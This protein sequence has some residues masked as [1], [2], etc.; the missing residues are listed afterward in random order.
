MEKTCFQC[1]WY[2]QALPTWLQDLLG[3]RWCPLKSLKLWGL[4]VKWNGLSRFNTAIWGM[5]FGND[6]CL[7][8]SDQK[9][10]TPWRVEVTVTGLCKHGEI[11][12]IPMW[13][14]YGPSWPRIL[15][16]WDPQEVKILYSQFSTTSSSLP[17]GPG[18]EMYPWLPFSPGNSLSSH[19]V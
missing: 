13:I 7:S 17:L 11:P 16:I 3:L 6:S 18:K 12:R 19:W 9:V 10:L 2:S 5:K 1:Y 15:F 4:F 14:F 8:S